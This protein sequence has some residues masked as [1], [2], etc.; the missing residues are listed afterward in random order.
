[1]KS[2]PV[3]LLLLTTALMPSPASALSAPATWAGK[4]IAVFGGSGFIGSRVCR[5][6]VEVFG[7]ASVISVSR[8]GGCPEWAHDQPW[9]ST[10]DWTAGDAAEDGVALSA[11]R[12]GV[13]AVVSCVGTANVF[14][15]GADGYSPSAFTADGRTRRQYYTDLNGP[16][17]VRIAEAA[18]AAGATRLSFVGVA[19]DVENGLRGSMPGTFEGK[20]AAAEAVRAALGDGATVFG[21]SAVYSGQ[22][23]AFLQQLLSSGVAKGLIVANRAIGEAG[24]RGEDLVTK[25]RLTPPCPVDELALALG[26][27]ALGAVEIG[28]SERVVRVDGGGEVRTTGRHVDGT[29]AILEVA[30][31][32]RAAL[33]VPG[34]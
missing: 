6:C 24:W 25:A 8:T 28:P 15:M 14:S 13:D 23:G 22:A 11:M 34:A 30:R 9:A 16:P 5:A 19:T 12:G 17:N 29:V 10:V 7:C 1:M 2:P 20:Q 21:P 3:N 33:G 27:A 18:A 32:A 4:R 31:R 26:A